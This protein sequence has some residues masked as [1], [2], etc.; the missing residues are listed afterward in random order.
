MKNKDQTLGTIIRYLILV[1]VAIPGFIYLYYI[2]SPLTLYPVYFLLN[3]IYSCTSLSGNIIT[4]KGMFL[5][6]IIGACIAGSAYYF[7]LIL[8]LSIPNIKWKKRLVM[9]GFAFGTFLIINIL[10]IFLLS[11]M[12]VSESS[13]FDVTHKVFWYLGSTLFVVLIWFI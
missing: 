5:I 7:L 8:N 6:E 1:I 12:Y 3:L 10:R 13:F 2:F 9:V 11:I 4:L